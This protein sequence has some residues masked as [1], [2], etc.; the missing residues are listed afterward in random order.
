MEQKMKSSLKTNDN[1]NPQQGTDSSMNLANYPGSK[2]QPIKIPPTAKDER[3]L[4]VGGLPSDVTDEEFRT[5][6]E[7]FGSVVDSVVM[8]DRETKNSRGFGF[9]TFSDPVSYTAGLRRLPRYFL[10]TSSCVQNV[11]KSLLEQGNQEDGV[12]RLDMRGKLCEV[13]RAEPKH[14][15]RISEAKHKPRQAP[16]YSHR[17]FAGSNTLPPFHLNAPTFGGFMAPMYYPFPPP[18]YA[19][20]HDFP[21]LPIPPGYYVEPALV[22]QPLPPFGGP[23]FP[24]PPSSFAPPIAFSPS[25]LPSPPAQPSVMQPVAPGL[26]LK[27]QGETPAKVGPTEE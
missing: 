4:F 14:P 3:K 11:A 23:P 27:I 22:G 19:P 10:R 2:Y 16:L 12:C 24:H 21:P 6:F 5:F 25:P 8:F 17:S 7:Q 15:G 18:M 20:P 26:P 9:V 13:K 1:S